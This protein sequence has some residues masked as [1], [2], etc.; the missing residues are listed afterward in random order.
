MRKWMLFIVILVCASLLSGCA[1]VNYDIK[2]NDD[3]SANVS[4]KVL[5][6]TTYVDMQDQNV[7]NEMTK[8]ENEAVKNGYTVT[9]LKEGD[10][11]GIIATKFVENISNVSLA[12]VLGKKE[13][14]T[15]SDAIFRIKH[16]IIFDKYEMNIPYDG[17]VNDQDSP[18]TKGVL[19]QM[20]V[21]FSLQTPTKIQG[22]GGEQTMTWEFDPK[23]QNIIKA[24]FK[25]LNGNRLFI[26]SLVFLIMIG[27]FLIYRRRSKAPKYYTPTFRN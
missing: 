3:L 15:D 22:A 2:V 25:V 27:G 4:L 26:Y 14:E 12:D 11:S 1:T 21:K 24:S 20:K 7:K 16:G 13:A 23:T 8:I 10:Q 5:I 19:S 9:P 17:L 18:V 6:D